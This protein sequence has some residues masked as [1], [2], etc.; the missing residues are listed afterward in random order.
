MEELAAKSV[1]VPLMKEALRADP[2][3]KVEVSA[4]VDTCY[5]A[6][7]SAQLAGKAWFEDGKGARGEPTILKD[8]QPRL[9]P[10]QGPVCVRKGE[11]L[12]LVLEPAS[13]ARA[14]IW[15]SL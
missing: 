6:A 13:L 3:T 2:A 10:P 8:V 15:Q 14:V 1:E 9:L 12:R 4:K 7:I 5:R 11:T